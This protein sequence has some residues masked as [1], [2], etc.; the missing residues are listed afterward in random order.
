MGVSVVSFCQGVGHRALFNLFEPQHEEL[1]QSCSK[2]DTMILHFFGNSMIKSESHY[3]ETLPPLEP[4]LPPR[5]IRHVVHP[6]IL[7]DSEMETLLNDTREIL[8]WATKNFPGKILLCGPMPRYITPCCAENA[9]IIKDAYNQPVNMKNYTNAMST[10]L[11]NSLSLPPRVEFLDY[12]QTISGEADNSF[13]P[14]KVHVSVSHQKKIVDFF[15]NTLS[16]KSSTNTATPTHTLDYQLT[17]SQ[18]LLKHHVF[19]KK[20]D[21]APVKQEVDDLPPN[22]DDAISLATSDS[23]TP[24]VNEYLTQRYGINNLP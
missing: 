11:K 5:R 4:T 23:L 7:S 22:I 13:C 9:H 10:H 1:L 15:V 20:I 6:K 18:A 8:E 21:I 16:K 12:R 17:F 3:P 24:T 14:D 2:N 19:A